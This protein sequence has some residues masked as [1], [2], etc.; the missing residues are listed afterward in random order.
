L[1]ACWTL[2]PASVVR[3]VF[4]FHGP[5]AFTL[6]LASWMYSDVPATNL[7]GADPV[8]SIAALPDPAVLR[9]MWYAKNLI[10][11]ML[12]TP[13]CA[14]TAVGI[15]IHDHQ[16]VTTLLT[17]LW[18]GTVPLGALGFSSWL[19]VWFPYHVLPLRYRWARR[20]RWRRIL[21]R[22]LALILAPYGVVPLLTAVLTVPSLL[23]WASVAPAKPARITDEQ[24]ARGLLLAAVLAVAAWIVGHRYGPRLAHR[25]RVGLIEFLRDPGRG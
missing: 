21:V 14:L 2:L 7:L 24:F 20:R 25:R 11:W 1:T 5:L 19:G 16:L 6:I 10:V 13:L 3:S 8:R 17:L 22:W 9:R 23:L 12:V 18:I 15:G 4:R